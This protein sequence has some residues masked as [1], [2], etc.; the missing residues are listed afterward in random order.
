MKNVGGLT[1]MADLLYHN[2]QHLNKY[3]ESGTIG[4]SPMG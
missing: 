4:H 1:D 2:L 3:T